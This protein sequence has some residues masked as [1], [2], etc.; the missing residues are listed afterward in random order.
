MCTVGLYALSI[1]HP[2]LISRIIH[3][4]SFMHSQKYLVQILS[5]CKVTTHFG[6]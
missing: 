1:I 6:S 4:S 2:D 5:I 3:Q